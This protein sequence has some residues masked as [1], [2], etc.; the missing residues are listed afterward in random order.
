MS[1]PKASALS[2]QR[3]V[4]TMSAPRSRQRRMG[5]ALAEREEFVSKNRQVKEGQVSSPQVSIHTVERSR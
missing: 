3:P 4:M 1:G 5:G 2:T